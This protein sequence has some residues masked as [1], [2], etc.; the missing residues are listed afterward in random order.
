MQ[1]AAAADYEWD[2]F[3]SYKHEP[4]GRLLI[5]PWIKNVIDRMELWLVQELGGRPV[6]IFFD[7]RSMAAGDRWPDVLRTALARS[8]C[9]LPIWSPEYFWSDWC[10][11]EW[12]SFRAREDLL[13]AERAPLIVPVKFHDGIRF[14]VEAQEVQTLDLSRHAGTTQAFWQSPRADELD[15][16]LQQ[17]APMLARAVDQAPPFRPDWPIH[18]PPPLEPPRRLAMSR[19]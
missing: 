14:P 7:E 9:L 1:T 16:L 10:M 15:Q 8:R 11:A 2:V 6:R 5:T 13:G 3:V 12:K 17:F 4:P 18:Q 19:L